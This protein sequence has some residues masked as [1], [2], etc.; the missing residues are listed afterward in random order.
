MHFILE[1]TGT[2]PFDDEFGGDY[3]GSS[4]HLRFKVTATDEAGN[5]VEDPDPHPMCFGGMIGPSKLKPGEKYVDSLPLMRYRRLVKPGRYTIT[6]KHDFGWKE[7]GGR[8]RP[9]GEITIT[10]RMPDAAQAEKI[11]ARWRNCPRSRYTWGEK[12]KTMRISVA[13]A[14]RFILNPSRRRARAGKLWR[15]RESTA[16]PRRRPPR[17]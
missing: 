8:K 15:E 10:L 12:S 7:E 9:V 2:Q 11:V 3:R 5:L 4:R 17:R 14:S 1:N 16:W 6:V 13:C